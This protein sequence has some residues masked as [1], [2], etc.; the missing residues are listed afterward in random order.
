MSNAE[1]RLKNEEMYQ[2]PSTKYKVGIRVRIEFCYLKIMVHC[3]WYFVQIIVPSTKYKVGIRIRTIILLSRIWYLVRRTDH[4]TLYLVLGT[5]LST[6]YKVLLDTSYLI[7]D[8]IL[9]LSPLHT[10]KDRLRCRA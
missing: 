3:T 5:D 1:R 10:E 7:L 2:V 6:W 8:T 4:G 9:P